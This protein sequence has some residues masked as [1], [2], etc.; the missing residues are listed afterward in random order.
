MTFK[1]FDIPTHLNEEIHGTLL[2]DS[3]QRSKDIHILVNLRLVEF[4]EDLRKLLKMSFQLYQYRSF[5]FKK[6]LF[7]RIDVPTDTCAAFRIRSTE[8]VVCFP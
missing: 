6:N 3:F 4:L 8:A 1:L 7:G 5:L 2:P